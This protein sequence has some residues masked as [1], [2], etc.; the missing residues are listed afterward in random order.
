MTVVLATDTESFISTVSTPRMSLASF[1][2]VGRDAVAGTR[3][4]EHADLVDHLQAPLRGD[5]RNAVA[6]IQRPRLAVDADLPAA[7]VSSVTL[8]RSDTV[9]AVCPSPALRE[10]TPMF[11]PASTSVVAAA[12]TILN[13]WNCGRR[14]L[15]N[16][17]DERRT[18]QTSPAS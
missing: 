15:F 8:S 14:P 3:E 5:Q 10:E 4:S 6:D 18:R 1:R 17:F 2:Q 13:M 7:S 12:A 16:A 9:Q 11:L